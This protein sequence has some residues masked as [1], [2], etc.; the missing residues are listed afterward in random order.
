M[1]FSL[2]DSIG[3]RLGWGELNST[4]RKRTQAGTE[5]DAL[6][7][8]HKPQTLGR[9]SLAFAR[10]TRT[11]TRARKH[12]WRRCGTRRRKR[13]T[14]LGITVYTRGLRL[15][16]CCVFLLRSFSLAHGVPRLS[17]SSERVLPFGV[18]IDACVLS[19]YLAAALSCF[20]HL[21]AT[22]AK[23]ILLARERTC[24]IRASPFLTEP[25]SAPAKGCV[26]ARTLPA[27]DYERHDKYL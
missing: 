26:C 11:H 5:S 4:R 19:S 22:A 6:C 25:F 13:Q 3:K 20:S 16:L 15:G 10:R 8:A 14:K 24:L 2:R 21:A 12:T 23:H 9:Q 7:C 27:N 1:Q 18:T 17:V